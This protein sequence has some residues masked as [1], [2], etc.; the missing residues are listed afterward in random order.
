VTVSERWKTERLLAVARAVLAVVSVLIV[1]GQ[2]DQSPGEHRRLVVAA[3]E[4]YGAISLGVLVV[5]LGVRRVPSATVTIVH[6]LD[7]LWAAFITTSTQGPNSPFFVFLSFVLVEAAFRWGLTATL[8][9]AAVAMGLLV[10]EAR[11]WREVHSLPA[12][13]EATSLLRNQL[14]MRA[15]F[16]LLMGFLL[17][18]LAEIEKRFR[19]RARLVADVLAG[20]Q[21]RPGLRGAVRAVLGGFLDFYR[22]GQGVLVAAAEGRQALA[23]E[24]HR[25]PGG[26]VAVSLR[27]PAPW[28][29]WLG[30]IPPARVWHARRK[31]RTLHGL[32]L[33]EEGRLQRFQMPLNAAGEGLTEFRSLVGIHFQAPRGESWEAWLILFDAQWISA[34]SSELRFLAELSAELG[35]AMQ[36]ALLLRRLQVRTAAVERGRIARELHDGAVQ[37]LLAAEMEVGVLE[38]QT[39][40]AVAMRTLA[41]VRELLH[42]QALM[43]R[44]LMELLRPLHVSP[45]ELP[46]V[47]AEEVEKFRRET[48]IAARFDC[49][50]GGPACS[51]AVSR[52]LVRIVQE[53]LFN[54]RRHSHATEA[55]VS[56]E[57][58]NGSWELTIEDNGRG[59]DFTGTRQLAELEAEGRGPRV[60][61]ERVRAIGGRLSVASQPGC[62]ARIVVAL[63]G[64]G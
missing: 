30:A 58:R 64:E 40:D 39:R 32:A 38:R 16:L 34:R 33:N 61:C 54:I 7:I 23:W 48:G 26:Q 10:F 63:P 9:T 53:G 52:E 27:K 6:V 60:I 47:L 24:A 22:A 14:A 17:G 57:R 36:Y 56:L 35:P 49:P 2:L 3:V 12:L 21:R 45:A 11:T 46:R 28:L 1:T 18:Y 44:N 29:E 20:V 31:R 25:M 5:L 51:P 59:F 37:S 55:V 43:L 8:W 42:Q 19:R 15:T 13:S 4:A 41:R 62:G 50:D